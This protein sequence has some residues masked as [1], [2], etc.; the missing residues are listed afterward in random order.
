MSMPFYNPFPLPPA[1]AAGGYP[2]A[3]D[4]QGLLT[5]AGITADATELAT[6]AAAAVSEWEQATGWKPFLA[7]ATDQTRRY[8]PEEWG[9]AT[10]DLGGGLVELTSVV[11][12]DTTLTLTDDFFLEPA[13]APE[14][15]EPYT[16]VEF[17]SRVRGQRQCIEVTGR[18][19][20][21]D[22]LPSDVFAAI[23]AKAALLAAEP[24]VRAAL[25]ATT[26][27]SGRLRR[28]TEGDVTHEYSEGTSVTERRAVFEAW[29]AQWN[30]AVT[31]YRRTTFV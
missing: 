18:W 13:S 27:A 6:Y 12:N 3:A 23:R 11:V 1:A 7:G 14:D 2:T 5:Q 9:M 19:G 28:V 10:L 21:C 15:G 25:N 16:W 4:I 22:E 20:Y 26:A 24:A 8:T 29:A 30:T 17:R 31:R